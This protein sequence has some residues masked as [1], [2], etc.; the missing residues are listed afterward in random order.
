MP[1]SDARQGAENLDGEVTVGADTGYDAH[2]SIGA[3][4]EMKVAPHVM[5][6]TPRRCSAVPDANACGAGY[7]I[8]Q[9]KRELIE[10]C[11]GWAKTVGRV[12]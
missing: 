1:S 7:A 9:Q 11:F 6:N 5:Q 3:C 4:L 10:Q 12:R 2:E 8:S